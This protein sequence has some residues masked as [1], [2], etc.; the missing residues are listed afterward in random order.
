[1]LQRTKRA[2]SW[3]ARRLTASQRSLPQ[4][5]VIG[6]QRCGTTSLFDYLSTHP[7]V[8]PSFRKEIHYFDIHYDRGTSWYRSHFALNRD[9]GPGM[10]TGDATPNY[11]A[12]S[13]A[14]ERAWDLVPEAKLLVL[15]RDPVERT[16]SSWRLN[17]RSGRET[18]TF[19]QAI[20]DEFEQMGPNPP[21]VE[22]PRTDQ[23]RR[24]REVLRY[25]YLIKSLYAEHLERWL[26]FYPREQLLVLQSERLFSSPE[27]PLEQ[28]CEFLG[29]SNSGGSD[30]P[31]VN[32]TVTEDDSKATRKK[33]AEYLAP[34]NQRLEKLLGIQFD[35]S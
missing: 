30:F 3:R 35:W 19:A 34:H 29:I 25:S 6:G 21:E 13:K 10:T 9:L 15:L 33:L 27:M 7:A 26:S 16:H 17:R 22:P 5:I 1:M 14:P 18:R 20:E 8:R 23:E 24:R 12:Y 31:R 2:L 11:L 28:I 32:T 4:F